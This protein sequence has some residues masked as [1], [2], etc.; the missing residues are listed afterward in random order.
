KECLKKQIPL[1][2]ANKK[3]L[4]EFIINKIKIRRGF[5][6]FIEFCNKSNYPFCITS[7]GLDFV[8]KLILQKYKLSTIPI[9]SNK[10]KTDNNVFD[11]AF[12]FYKKTCKVGLG[13]CKCSIVKK[14][15]KSNKRIY[16]GDGS[17]DYCPVQNEADYVIARSKLVDFCRQSNI[18][19]LP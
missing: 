6:N 17:S 11:V 13:N 19:Y 10:L 14:A 7:D 15:K 12:P 3:E 4:E 9:Y 5:I 2:K 18:N 1:I 16:I 8:I